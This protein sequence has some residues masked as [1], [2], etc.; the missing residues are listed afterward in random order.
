MTTIDSATAEVT[1]I[2]PLESIDALY[3]RYGRIAF[4]LAYRVLGNP[5]SAE[6][7]VQEA[8]L[9]VWQNGGSYRP[10]AGSVRNWLLAVVRN[11]AIDALRATRSRPKVVARLEE[12]API[13]AR[14]GDPAEHVLR[15][16]QAATVRDAIARL[17][18]LQRQTVE[19]TFFWGFSYSEV[20][21]QMDTP[22]GT[23]KSR[24]RLALDRLRGMLWTAEMAPMT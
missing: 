7:I 15:R 8:F 11:R 21:T 16:M 23:V 6:D 3:A 17:P 12:I 19:M 4:A 18:A 20:A 1:E 10:N 24:M 9:A 5:E 13:P 14:D 2:P 22:L